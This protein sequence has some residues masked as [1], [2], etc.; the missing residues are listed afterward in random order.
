MLTYV[1]LTGH[2][3]FAGDT[4]QETLL[5]ISQVNLEFPKELFDSISDSAVDFI[6]RLLVKEPGYD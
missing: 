1:M 3:P 4:K 5:N 2:S 6:T